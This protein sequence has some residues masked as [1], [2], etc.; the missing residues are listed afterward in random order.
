[1][2]KCQECGVEVAI[3][4]K[5]SYCGKLFC[6]EHRLPENHNCDS[7]S[8]V[9]TPRLAP[10]A[11]RRALTRVDI[12]GFKAG[13]IFQMTSLKEL[14]HLAVAL[15]VFILIGFSM[16][17]NNIPF[18]LLNLE[19]LT[20][21]VVG[22]VLSFLIHE[23]AHKIVAQRMGYWAEFRLSIP[24]LLLT[25]LSVI[26]PVKI[27]APGAV[28]VVGL[29][30]SKDGVGKIAF[31]GPLTNIIQAIVYVILLEFYA[32]SHLTVI[33]FFVLANLNLSLALF[34]LIPIDP[35]DGAK[36]F[37]WSK[38][39]WVSSIIAVIAL[40]LSLITIMF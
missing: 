9:Y 31:A 10:A 26:F 28:K 23:L 17:V 11:P 36:V 18:L 1:M 6:Y 5:C 13:S 19:V 2:V 4:F 15:S 24:G 16:L 14:K 7:T 21:T 20:I 34:N 8:R 37:K 22:M 32:Y 35:M 12:A 30:I 40:W 33:A 38:S 29:F 39:V 3:P 27:I 25:L